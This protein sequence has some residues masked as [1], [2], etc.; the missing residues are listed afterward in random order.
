MQL[1][2]AAKLRSGTNWFARQYGT[3]IW[4]PLAGGLL[5]GK[6]N[7][8]VP[9]GSRYDTNKGMFS[10]SIKALQSDEGKAK[11]AKVR[12]LT[13]IAEKLGGSV[14]SLSL[15][16]CLKNPNVSTVSRPTT[17]YGQKDIFLTSTRL[18][19]EPPSPTRS[20]RTSRHWHLSRRLPRR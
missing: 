16:W 19:S 15:A 1:Y 4:S 18:S 7:D 13:E 20:Q 5:T 11:I 2:S 12:K 8:G 10:D 9:E 17:S 3:T 14:A 6:Y